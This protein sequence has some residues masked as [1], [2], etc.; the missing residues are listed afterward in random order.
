M[1]IQVQK[2]KKFNHRQQA[3]QFPEFNRAINGPSVGPDVA[4]DRAINGPFN[5]SSKES[6]IDSLKQEGPSV[7]LASWIPLETWLE[8]RKMRDRIKRPMTEH[9]VDLAIRK[10]SEM[11]DSG[12]D[13]QEV[14]EQSILNSWQGLFSVKGRRNGKPGKL[15]GDELTHANLKAAGFNRTH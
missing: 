12:E 13:V 14:L 6:S 3:I 9:A 8:Y 1:R 11:R 15:T 5:K 7:P 4:Q 10:L 2:S